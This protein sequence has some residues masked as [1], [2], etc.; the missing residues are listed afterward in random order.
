MLRNSV[1]SKLTGAKCRF[2]AAEDHQ[3]ASSKASEIG[4]TIIE[5]PV[6]VSIPFF[7]PFLEVLCLLAIVTLCVFLFPPVFPQKICHIEISNC[8]L[9]IPRPIAVPVALF[10]P[11]PALPTT[12]CLF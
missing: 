4:A 1:K 10:S 5:L 2:Q 7:P 3:G 11:V 12:V 6:S 9:L 8:F